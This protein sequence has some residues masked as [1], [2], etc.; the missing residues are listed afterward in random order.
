MAPRRSDDFDLLFQNGSSASA[1]CFNP[2]TTVDL[3]AVF[4]NLSL[5]CVED[6]AVTECLDIRRAAPLLPEFVYTAVKDDEP[7][8]P[9]QSH[10]SLTSLEFQYT[11]RIQFYIHSCYLPYNSID[12]DIDGMTDTPIPLPFYLP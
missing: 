3:G 1:S 8:P 6:V 9:S 4:T 5:F 12:I 10:S 7:V 11:P 2:H